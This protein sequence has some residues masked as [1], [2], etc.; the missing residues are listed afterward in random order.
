MASYI[1]Q[2]R[3]SSATPDTEPRVFALDD[4]EVDGLL[5]TLSSETRREILLALYDAPS[6]P[7]DLTDAV[8]SSLQNVHYHLERLE[9]ADLIEAIDT[10]YSEKGTE[11]RVFAP[12]NDP[13]IFVESDETQSWVRSM[14]PSFLG[15]LSLVGLASVFVQWLAEELRQPA[16]ATGSEVMVTLDT[17]KAANAGPTLEEQV[18]A[19]L[20][21]P[22]M[23]V[24]VGGLLAILV[25]LAVGAY[26]NR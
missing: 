24:F 26:A 21:E 9:D 1:P 5:E 12:T 3:R 22:G 15:A 20:L 6:T 18:T 7:A 13:L 4:D 8:G 2:L 16:Y 10:R 23:L 14:L 17:S 11:M 19:I 25:V